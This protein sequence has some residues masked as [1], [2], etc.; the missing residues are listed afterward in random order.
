MPTPPAQQQQQPQQQQ[1]LSPAA[2]RMVELEPLVSSGTMS[3]IQAYEYAQASEQVHGP[4]AAAPWYAYVL[5]IDSTNVLA[6]YW[7]GVFQLGRGDAAGIATLHRAMGD[8]RTDAHARSQ[9][10]AFLTAR[11]RHEEAARY[12]PGAAAA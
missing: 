4:E 5:Q 6:A 1:Q 7:Y 10:V 9:V 11:G 2:Q 12:Q 3:P 8:V